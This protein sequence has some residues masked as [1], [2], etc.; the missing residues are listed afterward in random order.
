MRLFLAIALLVSSA[1][2][3]A[4]T[5]PVPEGSTFTPDAGQQIQLCRPA[6]C[7]APKTFTGP[8][9]CGYFNFGLAADNTYPGKCALYAPPVVTP[10]VTA[11]PFQSCYPDIDIKLTWAGPLSTNYWWIDVPASVGST[12]AHFGMWRDTCTGKVAGQF[13]N[14]S[15]VLQL[16]SAGIKSSDA[17][18]AYAKTQPVEE[19]TA[20]ELTF[21]RLSLAVWNDAPPVPVKQY[22]VAK[23]GAALTRPVYPVVNGVRKTTKSAD[24]AVGQPCDAKLT[25]GQ[26]MSVEGQP[27]YG[28]ATLLPAGSVS[29][30][31]AK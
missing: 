21:R 9:N 17:A 30:C 29:L 2:H 24:I 18:N 12:Y 10:P 1:A 26:Y 20:A 31:E 15:D 13:F 4:Q 19:Y 22:V 11:T 25:L 23:N 27:A 7:S 5:W 8:T 14:Y 28:K 3:A 6:G 16:V